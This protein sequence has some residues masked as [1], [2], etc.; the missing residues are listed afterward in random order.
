M[1]EVHSNFE[2]VQRQSPERPKLATSSKWGYLLTIQR[3]SLYVTA[4][5]GHDSGRGGQAQFFMWIR[6]RPC[7][8]CPQARFT[9]VVL[10][11]VANCRPG[12]DQDYPFNHRP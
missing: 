9:E 3:S 10:N 5:N 11:L 7:L 1:V 12:R 2:K 4:G 8:H 6:A